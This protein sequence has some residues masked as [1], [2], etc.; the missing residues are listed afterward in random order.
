MPDAG[1][2]YRRANLPELVISEEVAEALTSGRP[3]VA[4]ESAVIG[5]G[6]P[7]PV[8]RQVAGGLEEAVR[9]NGA[10]PATICLADGSIRIGLTADLL[11]RLAT[12]GA[13]RKVSTRDLPAVLADRALG[14]TT[15]A[16]TLFLAHRAGIRTMATGGIGG[17]HPGPVL[18]V[19]ADLVELSRTPAIVV[20]AGPKTIVDPVATA[21][22][23]ESLG[24]L[25]VGVG[26]RVLPWF[27]APA[28]PASVDHSVEA[29]EEVA[30]LA[31]WRDRLGLPGSLL[32]TIPIDA[33]FALDPDELRTWE[34][35][36]AAEASAQGVGGSALTPFLL[37]RLA[38][39]S[40][41][42]TLAANRAL[43]LANAAQAARLA[44][45]LAR[46]DSLSV[47]GA[48]R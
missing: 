44:A 29:I 20:C 26:T 35:Q 41:G 11:D 39:L 7:H 46:L 48:R 18:D 32:V 23:L 33:D 28:G 10:V 45:A 15:V 38:E 2:R 47:D 1:S 34:Q 19:S 5:S 4:L 12:P 6:L 42:R 14:A 8:N 17:V 24:V 16:A 21:E 30:P 9:R 13:S 37:R 31:Q 3:L 25:T 43:L 27:Y 22:M 36:A 40:D